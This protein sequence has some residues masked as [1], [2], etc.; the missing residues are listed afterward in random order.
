MM[1]PSGD[2]KRQARYKSRPQTRLSVLVV[3][4][5]MDAAYC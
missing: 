5:L 2:H 4:D 1:T 3:H